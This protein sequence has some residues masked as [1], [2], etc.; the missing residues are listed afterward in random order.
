MKR[1][2]RLLK[3]IYS[4]HFIMEENRT[5]KEGDFFMVKE[6]TLTTILDTSKTYKVESVEHSTVLGEDLI[7]FRSGT[8]LDTIRKHRINKVMLINIK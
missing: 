2:F 4:F 5:I 1:L 7:W 6:S 3:D 8:H